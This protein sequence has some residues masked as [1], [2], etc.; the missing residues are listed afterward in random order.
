[1]E[2][3]EETPERNEIKNDNVWNSNH[4]IKISTE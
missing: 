3:L 1:M 2:N 4:D